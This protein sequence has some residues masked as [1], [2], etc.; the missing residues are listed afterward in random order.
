L[1]SPGATLELAVV[2]RSTGGVLSGT[3]GLAGLAKLPS[4]IASATVAALL[5]GIVSFVAGG[6]ASLLDLLGALLTTTTEPVL[7][8]AAVGREIE[9]MAVLGAILAAP[10]L[11]L[12]CIRA[13]VRQDVTEVLRAAF[14]WLPLALLLGASAIG[15]VKIG[16]SVTDAMAS[17]LAAT[18]GAPLRTLLT[19]LAA[20]LSQVGK[21]GE[22]TS[23]VP[24]ATVTGVGLAAFGALL[25]VGVAALAAFLLFLELAVRSAAVAAATL[26][27]PLALVG[28]IWPAT[29]H[30]ARRLAET[31]VALLLAKVVIVGVLALSVAVVSSP[32]NGIAG[33]VEATAL[34]GIAAFAPFLLLRLIPI[35]ELGAVGHLEGAGR[36]GARAAAGVAGI[37]VDGLGAAALG[38][39]EGGGGV[40]GSGGSGGSGRGGR[41]TAFPVDVGRFAGQAVEPHVLEQRAQESAELLDRE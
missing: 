15:L 9:V 3:S 27:L 5:R 30:L 10:L 7:A 20:T 23:T 8:G 29:A 24:G 40:G 4:E 41:S 37:A 38:G 12:A 39:S 13:V 35:V 19:H 36:R 1:T 11:F 14:V 17:A 25:L 2:V 28:L 22:L 34:V 21:T 6:A 16:L 26:F 31:I 32:A 18:A 33:V